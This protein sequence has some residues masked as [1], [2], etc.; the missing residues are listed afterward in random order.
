[1]RRRIPVLPSFRERAREAEWMDDPTSDRVRLE[2]TL[3]QFVAVNRLFTRVRRV[4]RREVI[5]AMQRDPA[6]PYRLL[7]LGAGGCDTQVWLLRRARRLGLDLC[8]TACDHDA[9]VVEYARRR[10][11]GQAGLSIVR[12]DAMQALRGTGADFVFGNHLLHH[13]DD[14]AC[15][16][17]LRAVARMPGAR[18]VF[19]D[20]E[21]SAAAYAGYAVAAALLFRNSFAFRDGLL[22]VRRGFRRA[23][24]LVLADRA[25]GR[26]R[27]SVQRLFPH[28]L[29]LKTAVRDTVVR[30]GA[31]RRRAT[32]GGTQ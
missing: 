19:C 5:A 29:V 16:E 27:W 30:T 31:R 6:R 23:E 12:S 9:R 11:G 1:V 17:I 14:A 3:R 10:H 2:R 4:L 13:L 8:V 24:L 7:D 21:R 32:G 25:G 28:R 18:G 15:V 26:E 22:S 20:I